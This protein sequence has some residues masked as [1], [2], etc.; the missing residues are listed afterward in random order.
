MV[1]NLPRYFS[2]DIKGFDYFKNELSEK[3]KY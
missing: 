1:Y 2:N 3:I